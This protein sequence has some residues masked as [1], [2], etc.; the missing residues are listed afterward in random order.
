MEY[1]LDNYRYEAFESAM[2]EV[3]KEGVITVLNGQTQGIGDTAYVNWEVREDK[4]NMGEGMLLRTDEEF[5]IVCTLEK[6]LT[7]P[8]TEGRKIGEVTCLV[9]GEPVLKQD[10]VITKTVEEIDFEWCVQQIFSRFYLF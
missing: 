10:I 7:A 6:S 3:E 8:V 9:G 1:G 2:E 4:S 5:E